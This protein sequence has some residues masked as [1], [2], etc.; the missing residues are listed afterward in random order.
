MLS[1]KSYPFLFRDDA[2]L[3][4]AVPHLESDVIST[5]ARFTRSAY[6][7]EFIGQTFDTLILRL[8]IHGRLFLLKARKEVHRKEKARARLPSFS[9][10]CSV[11]RIDVA[12][13]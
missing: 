7:V 2:L 12:I 4:E 13:R 10:D 1:V 8:R 6:P 3:F 11:H 5:I 9:L